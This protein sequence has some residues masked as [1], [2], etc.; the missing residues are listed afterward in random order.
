MAIT[1]PLSNY[2]RNNLRLYI[3]FCFMLSAWC[4]YDGYFN[5]KWIKEHTNEDGSPETYLVFN[6]KAPVYLIGAAVIF[7]A[8]WFVIRNKK[9]VAEENEIVIDDKE[10]IS[11]QSIQKID[12]TNFKSKG[13]FVITYKD[14]TGKEVKRRLS[15]RSYNNL[16]AVLNELVAKIS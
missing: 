8:W 5:Q 1:A 10:K 2:K 15:D 16:E 9:V 11:Y 6:R 12:K 14:E 4:I 7:G 13:F 3:I